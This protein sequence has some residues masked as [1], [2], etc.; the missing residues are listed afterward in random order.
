MWSLIAILLIVWLVGMLTSNTFGG[1]LHMLVIVS[2]IL[3]A[4]G[5]VKAMMSKFRGTETTGGSH[6]I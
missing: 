5:V 3:A 2:A 4:F 1:I 6:E